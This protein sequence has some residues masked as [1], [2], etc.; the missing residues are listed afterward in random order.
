MLIPL[1]KNRPP[2]IKHEGWTVFLSVMDAEYFRQKRAWKQ[3][4]AQAHPDKG[5]NADDFTKIETRYIQWRELEAYRYAEYGLLPPDGHQSELEGVKKRLQRAQGTKSLPY[6]GG[7][8]RG[9]GRR[10]EPV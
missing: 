2:I 6:S 5:G 10:S 3:Q 8:R 7:G 1:I 4:R 9:K